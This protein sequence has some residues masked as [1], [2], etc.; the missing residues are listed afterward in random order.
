MTVRMENHDFG[1]GENYQSEYSSGLGE[2]E[3]AMISVGKGMELLR[4]PRDP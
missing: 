1:G 4:D 3:S 2:A